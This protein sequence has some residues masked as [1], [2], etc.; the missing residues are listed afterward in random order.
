V[1]EAAWEA[2]A[3]RAARHIP[4]RDEDEDYDDDLG[5]G[6]DDHDAVAWGAGWAEDSLKY[7][8]CCNAPIQGACADAAMRALIKVDAALRAARIEGGPALFVH[9]EI[10]LEVRADQAEQA[11]NI[12]AEC[13]TAAFAE[14]FVGAP[15]NGVVS[16][17][18][19]PTWGSAK[20]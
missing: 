2:K 1:I 4:W 15:L 18:I 7:T 11:R 17:G 3:E 6:Y 9:D 12:L 5:A 13:M 16:I 19:G 8:L 14:T 20:P 10:V